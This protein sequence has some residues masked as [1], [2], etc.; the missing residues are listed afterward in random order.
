MY[1]S[2]GRATKSVFILNKDVTVAANQDDRIDTKITKNEDEIEH[3]KLMFTDNV[4][5]GNKL[6][7]RKITLK[8]NTPKE[9]EVAKPSK[10]DPKNPDKEA[11]DAPKSP[12]TPRNP[13]NSNPPSPPSNPPAP[14]ASD[15]ANTSN[16][17]IVSPG[18][19]IF[20]V[21]HKLVTNEFKAVDETITY[22]DPATDKSVT[23]RI[24]VNPA[25]LAGTL[26][27]P[28]ANLTIIDETTGKEVMTH[29]LNPD[30]NGM[31]IGAN[32][33]TFVIANING[34]LIPFYQSSSGTSGKTV[35]Q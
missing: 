8:Q 7:G 25:A 1:T 32:G 24:Y 6:Y 20:P 4:V 21:K 28:E 35:D 11:A 19:A 3:S 14:P 22:T 13:D 34:Q 16:I 17:E 9:D 26:V 30:G 15:S 2:I 27:I 5:A 10:P 23:K 33:R 29:N 31:F 18:N 12:R